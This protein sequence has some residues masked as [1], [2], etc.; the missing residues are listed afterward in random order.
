M[1]RRSPATLSPDGGEGTNFGARVGVTRIGYPFVF[2][3]QI[4]E[5]LEMFIAPRIDAHDRLWF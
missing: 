5:P 4:G 2:A 1:P 3:E